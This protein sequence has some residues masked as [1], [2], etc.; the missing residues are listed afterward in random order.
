MAEHANFSKWADEERQ[1]RSNYRPL[2]DH[3]GLSWQQPRNQV[4]FYGMTLPVTVLP[5]GFTFWSILITLRK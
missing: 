3:D 5:L 2:L 4:P 1:K